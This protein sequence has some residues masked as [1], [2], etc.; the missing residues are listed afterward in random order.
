MNLNSISNPK[1]KV[2][3]L[4]KVR[5]GW[6][7]NPWVS[8]AKI[9]AC[10]YTPSWNCWKYDIQGFTDLLWE[11]SMSDLTPEEKDIFIEQETSKSIEI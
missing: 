3:Q 9:I 10:S 6:E 7:S 4:V 2:G 11:E 8:F 5:F 1:F